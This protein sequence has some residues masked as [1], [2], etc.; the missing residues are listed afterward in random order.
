VCGRRGISRYTTLSGAYPLASGQIASATVRVWL[1]RA[2]PGF[3]HG[4]VGFDDMRATRGSRHAIRVAPSRLVS[5]HS[6]ACPASPPCDSTSDRRRGAEAS[7]EK[8]VPVTVTTVPPSSGPNGGSMDTI[9]GLRRR[10]PGPHQSPR[11][12]R[13]R[14]ARRGWARGTMALEMIV[15]LGKSRSPGSG[16]GLGTLYA[17]AP[18]VRDACHGSNPEPRTAA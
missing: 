5:Q 11:R 18:C 8:W 2:R 15:G 9:V 7:L 16:R 6:R 3:G 4:P 10:R 13:G 1:A 17:H 12:R 14:A